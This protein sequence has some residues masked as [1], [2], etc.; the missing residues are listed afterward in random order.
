[1]ATTPKRATG[2][3]YRDVL[4]GLLPR[5]IAWTRITTSRI[6]LYLHAMGDELARAHNR[7]LDTLTEADPRTANTADSATSDTGFGG[8]LEDWERVLGLPDPCTGLA[9]SDYTIEERRDIAGAKLAAQGGATAAYMIAVA[10]R[11][12]YTITIDEPLGPWRCDS[13]GCDEP[14]RDESWAF[15]WI[16]NAT[17]DNEEYFRC[18]SPCDSPLVDYGTGDLVCTLE[19]LK[20]AHTTLHWVFTAAGP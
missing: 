11:L 6:G 18:D 1:M 16:V 14:I 19:A 2:A 12:G 10:A 17:Y 7:L 13:S 5:G 4:L 3:T 20:P 8:L 9:V 15:A